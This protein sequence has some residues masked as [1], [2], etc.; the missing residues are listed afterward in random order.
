MY[1]QNHSPFFLLSLFCAFV[2][3]GLA[4]GGAASNT[5]TTASSPAKDSTSN[6]RVP[7][8]AS[9]ETWIIELDQRMRSDA[10][11]QSE[12][13]VKAYQRISDAPGILV[14]LCDT[15]LKPLWDENMEIILAETLFVASAA[16][17]L[18]SPTLSQ[19]IPAMTLE[20]LRT[21]LH[22]YRAAK[23]KSGHT[24][25]TLE[26]LLAEEKQGR[27]KAWVDLHFSNCPAT[28]ALIRAT[29]DVVNESPGETTVVVRPTIADMPRER[30]WGLPVPD[31]AQESKAARLVTAIAE[32]A[33]AIDFLADSLIMGPGMYEILL[34][35][36]PQG[37]LSQLGTPSVTLVPNGDTV[38]KMPM[39]SYL[40]DT[41]RAALLKD[42]ALRKLF[43]MLKA[44]KI[45][46]AT[47]VERQFWYTRIPFEISG[48]P[49]TALAFKDYV[50]ILFFDEEGKLSWM[51]TFVAPRLK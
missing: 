3:T 45:R 19:D 13:I 50:T 41:D 5:T 24:T 16:A 25:E 18:R 21:L 17:L 4:C 28:I 37:T 34:E 15:I 35:V 48:K 39:R 42:I 38:E 6:E 47:E 49:V 30:P 20:S 12:E 40:D 23:Q 43:T 14:P 2:L 1:K 22:V 11:P 46:P 51:D 33:G 9:E 31:A 8:S 32:D 7:L 26:H 10:Q 36:A 29:D 27:L 44:A